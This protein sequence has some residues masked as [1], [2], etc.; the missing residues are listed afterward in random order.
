MKK[1][2]IFAILSLIAAIAALVIAA[3]AFLITRTWT[4]LTGVAIGASFVLGAF[5]ERER[6]QKWSR[7]A[8]FSAVFGILLLTASMAL[9][10]V[11][12]R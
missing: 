5:S 12:R 8:I 7:Y 1:F 9:L 6:A 4:S 3:Y 11:A 10:Y 2:R